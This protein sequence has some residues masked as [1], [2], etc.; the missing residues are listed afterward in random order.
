MEFTSRHLYLHLHL[1]GL[2]CIDYDRFGSMC[3]VSSW[4][5]KGAV[6]RGKKTGRGGWG[7]IWTSAGLSWGHILI[8]SHQ[9][10][11]YNSCRIAIPGGAWKCKGFK[12]NL[13]VLLE[14][15]TYD[16][17]QYVLDWSWLCLHSVATPWYQWMLQDAARCYMFQGRTRGREKNCRRGTTTGTKKSKN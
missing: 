14:V 15:E 2:M 5:L 3:H 11:V 8:K 1:F 16:N 12:C 4:F 13:R 10:S 17:L 7:Q 9:K 6:G